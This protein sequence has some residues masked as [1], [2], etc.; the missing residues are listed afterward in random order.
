MLRIG[1]WTVRPTLNQLERDGAAVK[2]E[3][4]TMD[5][6]VYLA[7]AG[8]RVVTADELLRNVWQGRVFDDG[9][10]YKRINQLRKALGDDPQHPTFIA[11]IPKR[12]YRLIAAVTRDEA[13]AA[14]SER[15]AAQPQPD[16]LAVHGKRWLTVAAGVAVVV[17]LSALVAWRSVDRP[18]LTVSTAPFAPVTTEP[19]DETEP[20]LSPDGRRVAF[21]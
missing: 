13:A 19:G 16:R 17:T 6:L 4:R 1:D 3:P 15:P 20:A 2:L 9:V 5:L 12:G 8:D 14:P 10:I 11:T 18:R 7:D 21:I